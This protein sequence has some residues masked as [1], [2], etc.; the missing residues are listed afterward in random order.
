[1]RYGKLT[2]GIL[3]SAPRKLRDGDILVYNPPAALLEAKGYKPLVY[4][5]APAVEAGYAAVSGWTETADEILQTWTT[6]PEG[7][8]PDTEALEILLGGESA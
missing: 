1:M 4:T 8:I 3:V 7:D 6:E 2:D 5:E